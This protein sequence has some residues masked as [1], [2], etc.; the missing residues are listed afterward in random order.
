M[1]RRR[2]IHKIPLKYFESKIRIEAQPRYVV[3]WR[4]TFFRRI[5]QG[6]TLIH[7]RSDV[8]S[9]KMAA[10]LLTAGSDTIS[11][12]ITM[13]APPGVPQGC[14]GSQGSCRGVKNPQKYFTYKSVENFCTKIRFYNNPWLPDLI[15]SLVLNWITKFSMKVFSVVSVF[16]CV[17]PALIYIQLNPT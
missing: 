4:P 16:F 10:K 15:Q 13:N 6:L 14:Q 2:F 7:Q 11:I 17:F 8:R 1:L 3:L 5:F 9:F 12:Q